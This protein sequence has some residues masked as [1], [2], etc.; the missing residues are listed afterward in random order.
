MW[1][2]G[3]M[4]SK[5]SVYWSRLVITV[6]QADL[7]VWNTWRFLYQSVF[8][9][10]LKIQLP[11]S[12]WN[13]SVIVCV[14]LYMCACALTQWMPLRRFQPTGC[15]DSSLLCLLRA[16]TASFWFVVP[17]SLDAAVESAPPL[18]TSWVSMFESHHQA[19]A[20]PACERAIVCA[21][22]R[23][24]LQHRFAFDTFFM[25]GDLSRRAPLVQPE[26]WISN[27]PL[28]PL[29]GN[30]THT[31]HT[32]ACSSFTHTHTY[33][34]RHIHSQGEWVCIWLPVP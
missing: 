12:N 23:H 17:H 4:W 1:L 5:K 14:C 11:A 9:L 20:S 13:E 6:S 2:K 32:H 25:Q 29:L 30:C 18:S 26:G 28:K 7:Y 21:S 16:R 3:H 31:P 34:L 27:T 24:R 22:A 19:A 10:S 33:S 8:W 15:C